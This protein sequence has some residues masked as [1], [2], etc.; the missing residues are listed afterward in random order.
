MMIQCRVTG[1][2]YDPMVEL[3]RILAANADVLVRL[4]AR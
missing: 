3:D 2:W 4:K 1:E